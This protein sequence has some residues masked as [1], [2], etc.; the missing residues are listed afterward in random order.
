[1][2]VR[3][4]HSPALS[5]PGWSRRS[6]CCPHTHCRAL[7]QVKTRGVLSQIL[8]SE[9]ETRPEGS[10]Y[11]A[12]ICVFAGGIG[13]GRLSARSLPFLCA[14]AKTMLLMME[15]ALANIFKKE[16]S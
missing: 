3:G 16:T 9:A 10:D 13:T 5:C 14:L 15:R 6:P 7:L 1:M 4:W 2:V 11:A 8:L 12:V